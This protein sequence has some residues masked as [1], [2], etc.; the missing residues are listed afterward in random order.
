V[1]ERLFFFLSN[2]HLTTLSAFNLDDDAGK[3]S[4]HQPNFKALQEV[5]K[6]KCYTSVLALQI[7]LEPP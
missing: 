1:V 5:K 6:K 7:E 2:I 4:K 3:A